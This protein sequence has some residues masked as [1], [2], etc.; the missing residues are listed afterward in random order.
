MR[1]RLWTWGPC[2][3]QDAHRQTMGVSTIAQHH[4]TQQV[5]YVLP[6]KPF[7]KGGSERHLES[8]ASQPKRQFHGVV[9]QL[10]GISNLADLE[11]LKKK[12][13]HFLLKGSLLTGSWEDSMLVEGICGGQNGS[14]RL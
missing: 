8:K 9:V 10:V 13:L 4:H 3:A 11:V 7:M 5:G 6:E 12:K 2:S 14:P 1:L